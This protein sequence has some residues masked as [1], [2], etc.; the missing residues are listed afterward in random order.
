MTTNVRTTALFGDLVVAAFDGAARYST[1]PAE[2]SR[3]AAAAVMQTLLRSSRA[4]APRAWIE[5]KT[6]REVTS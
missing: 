2:I 4:A 1:H 5:G 6:S 3:L